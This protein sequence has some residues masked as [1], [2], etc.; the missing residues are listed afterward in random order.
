M[1]A[2]VV[3]LDARRRNAKPTCRC[4]R[5]ELGALVDRIGARLADSEGSLLIPRDHLADALADLTHT[6]ARLLE[7]AERS[8]P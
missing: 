1:T 8:N 7:P 3:S 2:T 5:H 6:T 4:P